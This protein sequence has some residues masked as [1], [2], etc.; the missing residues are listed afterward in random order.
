MASI[1]NAL[2]PVSEEEHLHAIWKELGVGSGGALTRTELALV[3]EH[4]GM[5][6]MNNE[7]A[8]SSWWF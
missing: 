6:E 2:D 5:D 7:V 1:E 4:I 3:C 8:S